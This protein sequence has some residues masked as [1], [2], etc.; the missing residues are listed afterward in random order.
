MSVAL[1]GASERF[2][3]PPGIECLVDPGTRGAFASDADTQ[4]GHSPRAVLM[5]RGIDDV[6]SLV[7]WAN[8]NGTGIVPVSSTGRRRRG[9]TVPQRPNSVVADLSGLNKV[10]HADARDKI[11]IIEPGVDFGTVDRLLA[12]HGL[13]CFPPLM[14]RAGKS[15]IASYLEREPVLAVNDHWDT[16]DPF[17]GTNLVLGNGRVSPTGGAAIEGSLPEQLARGHRHMLPTGPSFIDLLRVVQGAQ[18]SLGIM[19]WAAIYCERIPSQ[20]DA[21]YCSADAL[22][23]VVNLARDLLHRRLGNALFIV[24]R[25][26]LAM[27]LSSD[28]AGFQD[29]AA[30]LP[31]W[32]LFVSAAAYRQQTA[33][34]MAWQRNDVYQCAAQHGAQVS[35]LLEG[36]SAAS[37]AQRLR[38]PEPGSYRDRAL[39]AHR[40][41]F[42]MHQLDRVDAFVK[43]VKDAL[44]A[45][46]QGDHPLGVYVQPMTQGVNCH[47]EFTQPFGPR[48]T[49]AP[50]QAEVWHGV[51]Q[52]CAEAGGFFSRPYGR[53]REFAFT[54]DAG[55]L[56]L[57]TMTQEILDPKGVMNPGRL[58]YGIA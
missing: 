9:D 30:R 31:A 13:R 2:N 42:F 39:G 50:E 27:L 26:Q 35:E 14:P 17:G 45:A 32:T 8:Q 57:M 46:G 18:G 7:Q 49:S 29:L 48:S 4:N 36:H 16:S 40:E 47:I 5:P 21:W 28:R 38:K 19:T 37:L 20:E 3:P 54:R 51:A 12:P 44:S 1:S 25:V 41:L 15:V 6:V 23:P 33:E 10:I 34:R 55:T 58:P 11:A 24:D 52:R 43:L 53:W 56:G 22:E